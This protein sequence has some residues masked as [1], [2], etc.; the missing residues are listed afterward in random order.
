MKKKISFMV[1]LFFVFLEIV[2]VL[3]FFQMSKFVQLLSTFNLG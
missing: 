3:N 2:E 1:F